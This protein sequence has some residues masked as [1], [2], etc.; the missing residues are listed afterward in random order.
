METITQNPTHK[1]AVSSTLSQ[2]FSNFQVASILSKL[3]VRKEKGIPVIHLLLVLLSSL[4]SQKT[5]NRFCLM[6]KDQL[7]FSDKTLRNLLNRSTVPW[8]TLLTAI[9][10]AVIQWVRLFTRNK[11]AKVFIIDDSMYNRG[12]SKKS[13][14]V[15]LQY[16]H[17]LKK[18][19][20]GFRFLQLGWSD[21]HTFLPV[22]FALLSGKNQPIAPKSMDRRTLSGQ[23]KSQAMR[24][25]PQVAL[26]LLQ[27]ALSQKIQADYVLF[28]SWFSSPTMFRK[29]SQLGLKA[30]A[31]VKK[32]TKVHYLYQGESMDVKAIYQANKK[33]RGRSRYLLE[34]LVTIPGT[35]EEEAVEAK[36]VYV[37]NRN[38][39]K[40]YLVLL[41]TDVELTPEA[42]IETYAKRWDIEVYFKMTKQ[43]LHLAK[44][45]GTSYDGVVAHTT[46][47][48][49]AY[50]VLAVNHRESIDNRT[51]GDLFYLMGEE[52]QAMPYEEALMLVLT[53]LSEILSQEDNCSEEKIDTV[54]QKIIEQLPSQLKEV[55]QP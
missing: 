19:T 48:C 24:K 5:L 31:M 4:F 53:L 17:A 16:D 30:I 46:L 21:G 43:Y 3:R 51:I 40:D 37:R 18:Y 8:H 9:S 23:R 47:V 22:S 39:R 12:K 6:N 2:F 36:L 34:V 54:I 32:T 14:L 35:E 38:K 20:R 10:A 42:I 55:L 15:A 1:L 49:L 11:Q 50:L 28:D 41:S 33:R 44:Y 7:D 25:G 52:L 13:E 29:L 27:Q 45:Q 26:E